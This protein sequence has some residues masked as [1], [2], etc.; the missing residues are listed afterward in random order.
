MET[1]SFGRTGLK[2]SKLCFGTMTIGSSDWK[3]WVLDEPGAH[4][5]LKR[6]LDLGI[7]FYDMANW[8][9]LGESERIV[10]S[11]LTSM[12]P[13]D[14]LVLA[15][16][17]LYAMSD[18]PND[19]GLSRKH[20]LSSVD[21]SL[22]RMG[23]DYID[24][25]VIH[26]YDPSTPIEE[27]MEALHDIVRS[28]KVRYLGASTMFAWQF[29]QMNHMARVHGWT[30]FVNMQCQY[31][32]LYREEER[33]MLPYCCDQGIAVTGFS[34]LARGWLSDSKRIRSQT[35]VYFNEFYGDDLD[36]EIR[37]KVESMALEHDTTLAQVALAWVC[38]KKDICCPIIGASSTTQLEDNVNAL[39]LE[40]RQ[41][42]IATLD[43]LYR[44]RDVINDHVT[45]PMPRL[46]ERT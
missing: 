31:S 12:V 46:L 5:I 37:A 9:S 36:R 28:G 11:M 33:E 17:A 4:P 16:K 15:T 23:T 30:P 22:H 39:Q 34:A 8:Y 45:N 7:T 18:D 42:E 13:R 29:E 25:F 10:T 44:P 14:H 35:D 40:L 43:A 32:L 26:G 27:T 21:A 19:R 24:L 6:C 1:I 2:V 38:S 41:D 3:P 20:L